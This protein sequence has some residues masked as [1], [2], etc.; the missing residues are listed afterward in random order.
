[1]NAKQMK[2][3]VSRDLIHQ[4]THLHLHHPC[5]M[6]GNEKRFLI[7]DVPSKRIQERIFSVKLKSHSADDLDAHGAS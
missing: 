5:I 3:D 1:M 7:R 6:R 4:R 2:P